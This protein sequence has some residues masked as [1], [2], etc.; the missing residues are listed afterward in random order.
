MY[1]Y[2]S[3]IFVQAYNPQKRHMLRRPILQWLI[4]LPDVFGS[5]SVTWNP[6]MQV[7]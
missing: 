7:K 1:S 2:V 5:F 6:V 4:L 3:C